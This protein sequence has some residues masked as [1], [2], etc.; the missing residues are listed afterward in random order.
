MATSKV[1]NTTK[2]MSPPSNATAS[3]QTIL[4]V[5]DEVLI[6]LELADYLRACGYRVLEASSAEEAMAVMQTEHHVDLVFSDVQMPG[7]TDGF[8]LAR[9]I[10]TNRPGVKVIL[11]SG[12]A[13]S[14]AL[15]GELCDE[16]PLEAKPYD[17]QRLLERIK[18]TLAQVRGRK[19]DP[20]AAERRV[21]SRRTAN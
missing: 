4:V 21:G 11:T 2:I 5:D 14:A 15:A 6:R 16:G 12:V 1:R 9:W 20:Q 18:R 17:P 7:P 19:D 13:R 3:S 8:G 10:R